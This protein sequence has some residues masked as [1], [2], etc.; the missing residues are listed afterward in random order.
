MSLNIDAEPDFDRFLDV[1]LL[2]KAWRRPP[3]FDFHIDLT[4]KSRILGRPVVSAEDETRFFARAGY[5]YA[6]ITIRIPH[7]ELDRAI[8]EETAASGAASHSGQARVIHSLD[9]FNAQRWSWQSLAEGDRSAIRLRLDHLCRA[10]EA[11]PEG[12]KIILHTDDVFTFTWQMMGFTELCMAIYES[13]DL[14][15]DVMRSLASASVQIAEAAVAAAGDRIGAVMYS[16]DIAYTEGLMCGP[17]F[18]R[19]HLIPHLHNLAAIASRIN[20]PLIYHSDGRLYDMF[21]N[22]AAAGVR[23]IQPL[24]PKSMDPVLI[25]QRWPGRFCLLGNI[26]LD[27]MTRG[28]SDEVER[29]VRDRIDT[30]N[31]RGG[32]MPGVSNTVPAY[33]NHDNYVRMI[34]TVYSYPDE[35]I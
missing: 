13:P 21:D 32:Y 29:M 16:D 25:Q 2:R 5:D 24:E 11:L 4:H 9:Q 30:L 7:E 1:L 14:V 34:R 10:A 8:A 12:M 22:L 20:A 31:V 35:P 27:L 33:V 26:D 6:Q 19:E 3:L 17:D 28:S 18:F 15:R 23:A